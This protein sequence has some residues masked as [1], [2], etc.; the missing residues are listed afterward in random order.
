MLI[1][2]MISEGTHFTSTIETNVTKMMFCIILVDLVLRREQLI[3]I[4]EDDFVLSPMQMI[5]LVFFV[6]CW[7]EKCLFSFLH[8]FAGSTKGFVCTFSP[9]SPFDGGIDSD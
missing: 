4:D 7:E 3:F 1:R 2:L 6:V 5:H 8:C 9:F